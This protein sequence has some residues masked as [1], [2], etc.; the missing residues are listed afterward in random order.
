RISMR[1]PGAQKEYS[2]VEA[3]VVHKEIAIAR[4]TRVKDDAQQ[5][6][7]CAQYD[8][9][10]D[11]QKWLWAHSAVRSD[12]YDASGLLHDVHAIRLPRRRGKVDWAVKPLCERL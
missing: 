3:G 12:D 8:Q 9:I 7:L 4:V 6:A 10:A 11:I 5:S 1:E 2:G